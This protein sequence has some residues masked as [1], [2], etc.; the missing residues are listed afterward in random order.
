LNIDV[1]EHRLYSILRTNPI[2]LIHQRKRRHFPRRSLDINN[3]GELVQADIAVM[4]EYE[5]YNYFLLVVDAYS[6]KV[7]VRPMK[8][9]SSALTAM[10]LRDIFTEFNSKIYVFETDRGKG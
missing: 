10:A 3:Y 8:N 2:F 7:F 9:K 4:F 6:T 1:S 5:S